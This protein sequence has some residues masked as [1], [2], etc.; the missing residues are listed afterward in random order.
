ML[1]N[2][3]VLTLCACGCSYECASGYAL[4]ERTESEEIGAHLDK[5]QQCVTDLKRFSKI[6]KL[7]A[8]RPFRSAEEALDNIQHIS[9]GATRGR[10]PSHSHRLGTA[11]RLNAL[12]CRR[13][14]RQLEGVHGDELAA[15]QARKAVSWP[16]T[17]AL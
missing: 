14:H 1:S 3:T 9:E 10:P 15:Y 17:A 12:R 8:F 16:Q 4:F 11:I 13:G 6:I 5:V 2:A 7:K